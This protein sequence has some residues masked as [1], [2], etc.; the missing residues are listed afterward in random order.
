[1]G[2]HFLL[3]GIF[4]TQ[5]LNPGLLHCRQYFYW[6][7]HQGSPITKFHRLINNRNLFLTG[8]DPGS[9]RSE[10]QCGHIMVRAVLLLIVSSQGRQQSKE[11]SS[12][13]TLI[14][15]LILCIRTPSLRSH[16]FL[17]TSRRSH[18]LIPSYWSI[19]FQHTNLEWG[20][21]IFSP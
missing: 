12:L 9:Q 8:L 15:A 6:L 5:G 20:T 16:L 7:R 1:M 4:P 14:K 17:I 13:M 10:C 2:C 21:Q 3:Q 18:L 19:G 11:G